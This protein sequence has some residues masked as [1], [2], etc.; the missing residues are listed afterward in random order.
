MKRT[1]GLVIVLA[2]CASLAGAVENV[3]DRNNLSLKA[4][5]TEPGESLSLVW[6]ESFVYPK[7]VKDD[8]IVSLGVRAAAKVRSVRAK[9]D[10][11]D[12][13]VTLVSND[14]LT[15]S[16]AY[17]L[18]AGVPD[19]VHVV[20][21]Q[22]S[23]E[24][25]SVQRTVDFYVEKS[26]GGPEEQVV[27][28]GET[29]QNSGWPLTVTATCSVIADG[30][31]RVVNAG[32]VLTSIA[33]MPWY[34]VLFS[35][36]KEGWVPASYVKEPTDD[37]YKLGC[38]A[39]DGK[40]YMAAVKYFQNA[41]AV[42]P[43]YAK[44][45]LGLASA[46]QA[47]QKLDKA[48]DAIKS[49]LRLDERDIDAR[50]VAE[51]LAQDYYDGGLTKARG[52]RWQEAVIAYRKAVELRPTFAVAWRALSEG[53]RRIGLAT[54][55]DAARV[56]ALK[57][58]SQNFGSKAQAAPAKRE[59][60]AAQPAE[61]KKSAAVSP[62]VANDSLQI[63]QTEKTDKGTRIASAIKSVVAMTKSLGTPI[64]EKG[65]VIKKRGAKVVVSYLCQQ[66]SGALE[67][68]D[69]LVDVDTRRIMPSNNN[70]RLL[71]SRW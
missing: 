9:F 14:G 15:W 16:G 27:S 7:T 18:P 20:R 35:D 56:E 66:G 51:K 44:G 69:W 6:L 55:A 34:K 33:K 59:L 48:A 43:N 63:V 3:V 26:A 36:G 58:E 53:F 50:V 1:I 24:R 61:F 45:Y 23:G 37:Y 28:Q 31:P 65:W 52:G 30:G 25:G 71:M 32:Q 11:A 70:A 62:L 60:T 42:D 13:P 21:Y 38:Q 12:A 57:N 5:P 47:Q 29:V 10:F 4:G 22:I 17:S 8:R 54:E 64:A 67:S 68:F 39:M 46:W 19:G 40:N 41:I 49:A 2:C